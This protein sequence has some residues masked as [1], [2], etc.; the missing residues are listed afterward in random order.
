MKASKIIIKTHSQNNIQNNKKEIVKR[1]P[2][3]KMI[4]N[5]WAVEGICVL[6]AEQERDSI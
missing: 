2:H 1:F 3:P 5:E 6:K 4:V